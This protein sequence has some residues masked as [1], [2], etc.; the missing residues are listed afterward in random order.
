M[1]FG[2]PFQSAHRVVAL[3]VLGPLA[4]VVVSLSM[5]VAGYQTYTPEPGSVRVVNVPESGWHR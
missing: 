4:A 3:L 2:N 5:T 1:N